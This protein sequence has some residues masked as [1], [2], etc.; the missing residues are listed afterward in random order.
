MKVKSKHDKAHELQE[1]LYNCWN[2]VDDIKSIYTHH[3][4]KE[5]L[6]EDEIGNVLI[7]LESLYRIKFEK[8][9]EMVEDFCF[10]PYPDTERLDLTSVSSDNIDLFDASY[11]SDSMLYDSDDIITFNVGDD[12]VKVDANNV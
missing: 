11:A 10:G 12:L 6:S 1:Q 5:V 3:L 9:N 4:D 8:L 7:G 2:V